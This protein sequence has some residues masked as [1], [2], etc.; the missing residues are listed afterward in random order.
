MNFDEAITA[1]RQWKV[2]L[3]AVIDATSKEVLDPGN[4]AVDNKCVLG[5]WIHG[6][7]RQYL[8][9][10]QYTSLVQEHANFHKCAAEVLQLAQTGQKD[11]A[12][13]LLDVDGPFTEASIRTINAIRHL[14]RKVEAV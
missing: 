6:D 5:Q 10:A 1:H 2:R 13:M 12:K 7:A 11:R 9:L 3:R 14:R 8:Q 4:I